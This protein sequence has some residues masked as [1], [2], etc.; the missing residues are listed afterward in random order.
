MQGP[1]RV[2][3][4]IDELITLKSAAAKAGRHI[5]EEDLS[6]L[7]N[8]VI[9]SHHG[10]IRWIGSAAEFARLN[11]STFTRGGQVEFHSLGGRTVLPAFVECHTHT[12]FA[13]DRTEEF[14]WRQQGQT[15]QEIAQKG[16][17][18]LSTVRATRSAT[19]EV[20]L[21]LAEKRAQR[22]VEQG[23]T[24]LE[25][26]SGYGLNLESELKILRVARAIRGPRVVTT[27]LGPHSRAPE[28]PDCA[29][30]LEQIVKKDLPH[31]RASGLADRAD[32]YLEQ[33]FFS[34]E[35]GR[36]FFEAL[37]KLNLPYCAHVEQLSEFGGLDLAL[38]F[39]PQSVDHAVYAS[40]KDIQQL[41]ASEATAVLLPASDLYLKMRYPPAQEMIRAGVRVALATDFNPGTSPTQDLSL[42]GVLAR[43]NMGLSL[44]QVIAAYTVGAAHALG[45][46]TDLG[47]L[48]EGKSCDFA[49]LDG[50]WKSLF[51]SIGHHPVSEVWKDGQLLHSGK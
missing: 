17:G 48:E 34:L 14:E 26:K 35:E 22:F 1:F 21:A 5:L 44:P 39:R 8:A 47:S 50:S 24:T 15:Y 42:V 9:L 45:K 4:E 6:I 16:G 29:A 25:I 49:V 38:K 3:R 32:I 51:Y 28:F 27:Y 31:V 19:E 36:K 40:A 41:A 2:F 12:V 23:V 13:G 20:L 18:I 37:E 43:L 7:K 33:G 10:R 46:S 30:Y 11:I